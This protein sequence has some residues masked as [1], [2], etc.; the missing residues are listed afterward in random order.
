MCQTCPEPP[1]F[2]DSVQTSQT[3]EKNLPVW[4]FFC[5]DASHTMNFDGQKVKN[6]DHRQVKCK[7]KRSK[8]GKVKQKACKWSQQGKKGKKETWSNTQF[9]AIK[10]S[11]K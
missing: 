2:D 1:K 11:A 6:G 5:G 10:C 8:N 4:E 7:C 3:F 9:T